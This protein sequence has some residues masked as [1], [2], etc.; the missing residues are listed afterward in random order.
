MQP[1]I[2][3]SSKISQIQMNKYHVFSHT[4]NINR[5]IGRQTDRQRN[6]R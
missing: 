6:D 3:V 4:K 5:Y 2:I 1:E